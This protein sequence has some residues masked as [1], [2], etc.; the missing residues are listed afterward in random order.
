MNAQQQQQKLAAQQATAAQ[1]NQQIQNQLTIGATNEALAHSYQML[2]TLPTDLTKNDLQVQTGEQNLAKGV[3]DI[4][5]Q[6]ADFMKSNWGLTPAQVSGSASV[7]PSD[8]SNSKD[9]LTRSIGG[10]SQILGQNDP[11]VVAAQQVA[12]NPQPTVQD[13]LKAGSGLSFALQQNKDVQTANNA[14][15][16]GLPKNQQEAAAQLAAAQTSGDPTKIAKAQSVYDATTKAVQDERQFSSNLA[17]QNQ[18]ANKQIALQNALAQKG[19]ADINKMWTDPREGF[20]QVAAQVDATKTIL[21]QA[22]NGSELAASLQPVLTTLGINSFAG[23]HRISPAEVQAAGPQVGSLYRRLNSL[24]EK[25]TKGAVPPAT[26]SEVGGIMD[27]LI[28]GKY[29]TALNSTRQTVKNAGLSEDSIF[30]PT[31]NNYGALT[32]LAQIPVTAIPSGAGVTVVDP[33][34]VV[35]TFPDQASADKFKKLARIE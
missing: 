28:Q 6:T 15:A 4:Q 23:V 1:R 8:L 25:T 13:I 16:A 22:K 11:A 19:V 20:S 30:V 26:L 12:S 5:T 2:M 35:H 10:A 14:A 3:L 32:A 7:A 24:L 18:A 34:G 9:M 33:R 29:Q 17:A 27:A 31:P 21:A